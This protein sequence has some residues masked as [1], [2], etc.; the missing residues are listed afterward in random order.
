MKF[1]KKAFAPPE[2]KAALGVMDEAEHHYSRLSQAF[3]I[4][5]NRLEPMILNQQ[6]EI[7]KYF[8][9]NDETPREFVYTR[10]SNIAGDEVESGQYHIYIGVLN[11]MGP[12]GALLEMFD[13]SMDLVAELR[14]IE[15]EW[16][17][18]QKALI[19]QNIKEVG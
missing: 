18:E 7:I 9:E 13:D 3:R 15:P 11:P 17:A 4:V 1:F 10:I 14:S 16:V 8:K 5:K 19:R 6:K 12:G 2:V